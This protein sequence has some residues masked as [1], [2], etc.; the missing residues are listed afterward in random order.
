MYIY[1]DGEDR[2][3]IYENVKQEHI[4]DGEDRK[5]IYEDVKQE[6]IPSRNEPD[7][8]DRK[9]KRCEEQE[10]I[11][12]QNE[13]DPRDRHTFTAFCD[14]SSFNNGKVNCKAGWACIFPHN[15]SWDCGGSLTGKH[16]NV[17]N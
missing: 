8:G 17:R 1:A 10:H 5:R 12:T 14:G 15:R 9:R 6:H 7:R 11:S 4:P 3:R 2:K 13:P 16:T